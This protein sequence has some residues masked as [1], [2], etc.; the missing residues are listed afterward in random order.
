MKR[1]LIRVENVS[2]KFCRSLKRSLWYGVQDIGRELIGFSVNTREQLRSDEFWSITDLSF[3]LR[4]GQCLGLIGHNGAGKSTLLKMINGLIKPDRGKITTHGRVGALIELGA[5]FNPILTGKENIYINGA[6]LGFSRKEMDKRLDEIIEFSELDE[7][8]DTPLQNYSSGMKVRLG[9]SIAVQMDPDIL[10]ID[11]VLAVG[12]IGFRAKCY[13]KLSEKMEKTAIIFVSHSMPEIAR[14]CSD[15]LLLERGISQFL[16]N[17]ISDAINSYNKLHQNI[18]GKEIKSHEAELLDI[19][20]LAEKQ[21]NMWMINFDESISIK[22]SA[23]VSKEVNNPLF[24][25]AF[26]NV[27]LQNILHCSSAYTHAITSNDSNQITMMMTL[28]RVSL[29]PGIYFVDFAITD[30]QNVKIL[31]RTHLCH[32]VQVKGEVFGYGETLATGHWQQVN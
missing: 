22:I 7:F 10:L 11:E 14:L 2:K 32:Q 19:A 24:H 30:N 17:N 6:V 20:I 28:D 29:R 1:P 4:R 26:L 25:V 16:G 9:F 13:A 23:R 31:A 27:S 3:E 12:D 21:G 15:I 8:I 18:E 5:G